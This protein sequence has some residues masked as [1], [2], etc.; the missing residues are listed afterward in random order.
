MNFR[1]EKSKIYCLGCRFFSIAVF[2]LAI[3]YFMN[4]GNRALSHNLFIIQQ[5][6]LGFLF[7]LSGTRKIFA[8]NDKKGYFDFFFGGIILIIYITSFLV[9]CF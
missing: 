9:K 2:V 4:R 8:E 1:N 5:L 3:V 7:I 6:S